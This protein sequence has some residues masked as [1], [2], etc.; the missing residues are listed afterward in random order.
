[1]NEPGTQE[2]LTQGQ[3]ADEARTALEERA[4][5]EGKSVEDLISEEEELSGLVNK[6]E[7]DPLKMAKAL[8]SSAQEATRLIERQKALE[9]EIEDLH[10]RLASVNTQPQ[11]GQDPKE[12][13][14]EKLRQKYPTLDEDIIDAMVEQQMEVASALRMEYLMDKANDR[15]EIEKEALKD[16]PYYKKY[17]DEI[18]KL[19]DSQPIQLKMQKGIVKR[20]RDLVV[21]QHVNEILK[22][23]SSKSSPEREIVGQ[24]RGSKPSFQ[25]I[26][27][28]KTPSLTPRQAD[29][30][31]KM[32]IKPETYLALLKKHREEAK[33]NGFPEP[34]L[35]TDPWKKK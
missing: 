13:V 35:L 7:G 23:T 10:R 33:K 22:E 34:E 25:T 26:G 31:Q 8:K 30:A 11:G 29:Q 1:M 32:G 19:I 27:G 3:E 28:T 21:G 16:D 2:K 6:Y 12:K 9:R 18:D 15:I 20:C 24:I 14:K 4:K 5:K 17:K